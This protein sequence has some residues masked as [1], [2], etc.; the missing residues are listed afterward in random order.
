MNLS[1]LL[2]ILP[3]LP[4]FRELLAQLERQKNGGTEPIEAQSLLTSARP[5]VAAGLKKHLP[6]PLVL[7]TSRSEAAQQLAD[8]LLDWLPP[9]DEGGPPVLH[10]AD[11]DSLPF[12]RISWSSITRQRRLTAL[13]ALQSKSGRAPVV[14]DGARALMQK[15]LPAR[16]LR[17]ALRPLKVGGLVRLEQMAL[18]WVQTGYHAVEVVEEPG[19]F[20]RRGGIID[21]WPPN[22]PQPIR[23][24]LFG[25]EI[26]SLRIF[27]PTTQRSEGKL[28]AIE[29]GPGSEALSKY[30]PMALERIGVKGGTL[31]APENLDDAGNHSILLDSNLLLTLREEIRNEVEQLGRAES[32]HGIEWYLPY[33]YDQPASLLDHLPAESTLLIDDALDLFATIH[34]QEQQ[35]KA[36]QYELEHSGELPRGFASSFFSGD[37]L[38][39]KLQQMQPIVQGLGDLY[40]KAP[41]ANKVGSAQV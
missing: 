27:D 5:F 9:H 28:Q 26:E 35:A 8:Q 4:A 14:V 23:I 37:E 29:I 1:G 7:I 17:M 18:N 30:G 41:T 13:S 39:E 11:P 32:F 15:T 2:D 24:D 20:A 31:A 21:I 19:S 36:L 25:D 38:R 34:E 12:E 33:F 10:F 16:E 3:S 22:L 40:G 6:G